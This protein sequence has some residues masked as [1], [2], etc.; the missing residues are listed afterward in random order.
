MTNT[1]P[2]IAVLVACFN[3]AAITLPNIAALE[4]A[5]EAAACTFDIHL[6]DD[7]SPDRTGERVK[8]A[9]P[10]INVVV[11]E[12]DL[13]WNRG[14]QRIFEKARRHGPYD[15]Y[16]LYNDDVLVDREAVVQAVALWSSLDRE[17]PS[18]LVGATRAIDEAR[19]TYSGY[20]L[21]H[22]GQLIIAMLEPGREPRPC[23][24]FNGNFVLVPA[25]T[26]EELGGLDTYYWHAFGDHDL[27][28]M[29]RKRG[30]RIMLAPGWIG[31][32]DGHIPP[33]PSRHGLW[34]RLRR[35]LTGREDPR[36][37]I[38]MIRKHSASRPAALFAIGLML[39]KRLRILALNRPHVH[40]HS[41]D[42]KR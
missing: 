36:Q 29:I 18:T 21:T 25:A 26:L 37:R 35:G 27:G 32:C 30:E 42:A 34:Q 20:D 11:S 7:A 6:L 24:T 28:L 15:G 17:Q 14:M 41:A 2:R 40:A 39:V 38:Y 3:R 8:A 13:F 16:L 10:R 9:H 4:A 19:T 12:G 23:D 31:A 22:P 1:P 33:V 5:L